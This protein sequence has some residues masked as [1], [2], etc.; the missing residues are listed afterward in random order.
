MN[1]EPGFLEMI[2]QVTKDALAQRLAGEVVFRDPILGMQQEIF[3]SR[4]KKVN[5]EMEKV[6][7]ALHPLPYTVFGVRFGR[8]LGPFLV[9]LTR[10]IYVIQR[11]GDGEPYPACLG[12]Y[13]VAIRAYAL[14][15][16]QLMDFHFVPCWNL[17]TL[18]RHYHHMATTQ[19]SN[20]L[21]A[22][23]QT[24]WASMGPLMLNALHRVD[25]PGAFEAAY[26]FLERVDFSSVLCHPTHGRAASL[27][28][29]AHHLGIP[30]HLAVLKLYDDINDL[31]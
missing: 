13:I 24:C 26:L 21:N 1:I 10:P 27:K 8:Y 7:S 6:I 16:E 20:P 19:D 31:F 2:E 11:D 18:T 29:Y 3:M 4:V 12:P 23:T 28:E 9:G 25:I 14:V 5:W 17:Q 15:S 30:E 22:Q